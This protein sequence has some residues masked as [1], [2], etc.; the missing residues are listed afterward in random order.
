MGQTEVINYLI[1]QNKPVDIK[2]MSREL[3]ITRA[4]VSRSCKV[5]R[6]ENAIIVKPIKERCFV[7][8]LI[9]INPSY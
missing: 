5:L 6:K 4:N 9:T 7:R 1:K 8:Y 3:N 2:E